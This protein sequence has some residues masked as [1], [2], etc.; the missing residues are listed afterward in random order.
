MYFILFFLGGLRYGLPLGVGIG[1]FIVVNLGSEVNTIIIV[2]FFAGLDALFF[3]GFVSTLFASIFAGFVMAFVVLVSM[4]YYQSNFWKYYFLFTSLDSLLL[5][6]AVLVAW[7]SLGLLS[8]LICVRF[9]PWLKACQQTTLWLCKQ[10]L[11][12]FSFRARTSQAG[13][14]ERAVADGRGTPPT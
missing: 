8:V 14:L 5:V 12:P 3:G 11:S 13:M 6:S 1:T 2:S 7:L 4:L 9:L 10:R